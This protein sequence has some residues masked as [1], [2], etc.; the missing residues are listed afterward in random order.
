LLS[1][2]SE[3]LKI[4]YVLIVYPLRSFSSVRFESI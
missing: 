1:S 4:F 2:L 3:G